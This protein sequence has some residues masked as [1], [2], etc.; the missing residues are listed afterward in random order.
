LRGTVYGIFHGAIGLAALPA[1]LLFG[2]VW[3]LAGQ[4]LPAFL[5]GA[6][7]AGVAALVLFFVC[8]K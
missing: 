1:S 6:G 4:P 8:C 3:E 5:M 2:F 7:F